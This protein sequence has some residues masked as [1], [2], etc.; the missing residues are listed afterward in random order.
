MLVGVLESEVLCEESSRAFSPCGSVAKMKMPANSQIVYY[1]SY[2]NVVF[3]LS[4]A[5]APHWIQ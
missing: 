3:S 2:K 1:I 5:F 4:I